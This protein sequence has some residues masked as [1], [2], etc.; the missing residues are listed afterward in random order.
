MLIRVQ[1]VV[2]V[3]SSM[4][5]GIRLW[6]CTMSGPAPVVMIVHV[7]RSVPRSGFLERDLSHQVSDN[8]GEA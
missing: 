5:T 1:P 8:P 6:T 2:D 7:W 4:M 3:V